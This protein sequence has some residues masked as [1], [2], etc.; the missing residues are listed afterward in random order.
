MCGLTPSTCTKKTLTREIP[1]ELRKEIPMQPAA[2][3]ASGEAYLESVPHGDALRLNRRRGARKLLQ[4]RQQLH[5][6]AV[7]A[8]CNARYWGMYQ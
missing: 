5:F 3:K 4:R 8:A 2:K 6:A 1:R 7:R